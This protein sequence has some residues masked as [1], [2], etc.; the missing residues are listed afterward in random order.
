MKLFSSYD[1]EKLY[2]VYLNELETKLYSNF[3]GS[4]KMIIQENRYK[5]LRRDAGKLSD[6]SKMMY[7]KTAKGS[8]GKLTE[9]QKALLREGDL[10]SKDLGITNS[11]KAQRAN[12]SRESMISTER[13]YLRDRNK[14]LLAEKKAGNMKDRVKNMTSQDKQKLENFRAKQAP[15]VTVNTPAVV[16]SAPVTTPTQAK[17]VQA[18]TKQAAANTEKQVVNNV[19]KKNASYLGKGLKFAK[20]HKLGVGLGAAGLVTA[21]TGAA[22]LYNKNKNN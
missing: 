6:Y 9:Q 1:G 4:R 15:K 22:Y 14:D 5:T 20:N 8:L 2:T 21:G 10:T 13:Q 16:N 12:I 19:A 11:T 17:V 18:Q 7:D 3:K